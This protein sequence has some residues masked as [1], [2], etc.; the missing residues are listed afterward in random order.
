MIITKTFHMNQ[1]VEET[2]RRLENVAG[3]RQHLD[4]MQFAGCSTCGSPRWRLQLP[5]GVK[6]VMMLERLQ[7]D[8]GHT[9]LFRSKGGDVELT[10]AV[11]FHEIRPRLTEVELLLDYQSVSRVYNLLDRMLGIGDRFI[12]KQLSRV[13]AHFEGIA[14]PVPAASH[15]FQHA[16][17]ATV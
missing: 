2:Q 7:S 13:R 14:A 1:S 3:Y 11:V 12:V 8:D 17:P 6:A 10:G 9:I 16:V 5:F 15:Y 4:G